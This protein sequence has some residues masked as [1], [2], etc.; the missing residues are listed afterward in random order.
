[1]TII[2][3]I[4]DPIKQIERDLGTIAKHVIPKAAA[5]AINRT[6]TT[7][8]SRTV[9]EIAKKSGIKAKVVR[10]NVQITLRARPN[11]LESIVVSRATATNLIEFVA[12]SK[13]RPG[14]F[15][16]KPGVVA[17][18]WGKTITP[19]GTFI[20]IGKNSGKPVVVSRRKNARR[21]RGVW[22]ADWSKTIYGPSMSPGFIKKNILET[23]KQ[24]AST[25]FAKNFPHEVRFY[26]DRYLKK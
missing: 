10:K 20:V 15:R 1:M 22:K 12:A 3:D 26:L 8:A 2:L 21:E 18:A 16:N 5:R 23:Q 25:E 19:K 17:K 24:I 9:R 13:R 11:Q 14:A 6:Q 7:V 4:K